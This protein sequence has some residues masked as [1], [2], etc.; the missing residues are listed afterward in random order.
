VVTGMFYGGEAYISLT[1]CCCGTRVSQSRPAGAVAGHAAETAFI[2]ARAAEGWEAGVCG[3]LCRACAEK[4]QTAVN[5][6][7]SASLASG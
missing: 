1:C 4:E 2:S 3:P 7:Q 5:N 6:V